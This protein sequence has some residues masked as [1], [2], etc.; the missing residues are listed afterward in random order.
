[1]VVVK[2]RKDKFGRPLFLKGN[3]AD[4]KGRVSSQVPNMVLLDYIALFDYFAI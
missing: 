1:M 4:Y 2:L 3:P